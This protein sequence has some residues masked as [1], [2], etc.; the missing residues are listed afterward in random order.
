MLNNVNVKKPANTCYGYVQKWHGT[1]L[2]T[3]YSDER[4]RDSIYWNLTDYLSSYES[5]TSELFE[6]CLYRGER[7]II[8]I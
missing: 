6:Y 4:L 2:F 7:L 3:K 8:I 5:V 1:G